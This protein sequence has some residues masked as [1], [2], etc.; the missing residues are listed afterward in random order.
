MLTVHEIE[1]IEDWRGTE[2]ASSDGE[3]LGKLEDLLYDNVSGNAELVVV[4]SGRLSVRRMVVPLVGAVFGRDRVRLA[5]PAE[6]I[7]GGPPL[8]EDSPGIRRRDELAIASYYGLEAPQSSVADDSVRY[9]SATVIEQ[10]R[11]ATEEALRRAE[12]LEGLAARKQQESQIEADRAATA[13]Q[14]AVSADAEHRQLLE[15]AARLRAH[16]RENP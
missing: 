14:S 15:E 2:V 7:A 13:Q 12:E 6:Q 10:R 4:K 11:A 3:R 16:V 1:R 5:F 9:E 8:E